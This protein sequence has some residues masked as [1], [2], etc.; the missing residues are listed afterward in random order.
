M[1]IAQILENS[2]G[3]HINITTTAKQYMT[4]KISGLSPPS[5]TV[6]T[7]SCAGMDINIIN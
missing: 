1:F 4:S 2:S 5:G 3:I 7:S 6:S